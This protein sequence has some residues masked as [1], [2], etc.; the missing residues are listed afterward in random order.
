MPTSEKPPD[1]VGVKSCG[2][3]VT[4]ASVEL[5]KKELARVIAEWI[6]NGL[7]VRR[8]TTEEARKKIAPCGH[9]Q[10]QL[11]AH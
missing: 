8:M 2:C 6:K 4:W 5:P 10:G 9:K 3:H 1:Y 7:D 11:A